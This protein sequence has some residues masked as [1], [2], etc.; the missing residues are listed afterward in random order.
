MNQKLYYRAP[1][2]RAKLP[3]EFKNSTSL[4]E[5]KTKI[6]NWKGGKICP[7]RLNKDYLPDVDASDM[8]EVQNSP[9]SFKNFAQINIKN[10]NFTSFFMLYS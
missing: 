6:N 3:S 10:K 7:C 4:S 9:Y 5:F 1:F 8:T 2:L